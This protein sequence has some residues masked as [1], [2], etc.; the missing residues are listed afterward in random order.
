MGTNLVQIE[1]AFLRACITF[2]ISFAFRVL[3]I[4]WVF[5]NLMTTMKKIVAEKIL[6]HFPMLYL[7]VDV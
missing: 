7:F 5:F 2:V 6:S 3:S 1:R 4:I